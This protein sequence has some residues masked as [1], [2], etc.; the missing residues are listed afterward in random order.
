MSG[1]TRTYHV[2]NGSTD[3]RA[4]I[5]VALHGGGGNGPRLAEQARLIQKASAEGS[6]L[7]LP[8]GAG[9]LSNRDTWF[10]EGCCAY[11]SRQSLDD[12][13]IVTATLSEVIDIYEAAPFRTLLF[14]I[15]N[16]GMLAHRIGTERPESFAAI[17]IVVGSMFGG[18]IIPE[19]AVP[20]MMIT[21]AADEVVP[22]QG[23]MSSNKMAR[24]AQTKPFKPASYA[25]NFWVSA[26]S[27]VGA[28]EIT[29]VTDAKT[30]RYATC[31]GTSEVIHTCIAGA[32]HGWPGGLPSGRENAVKS[33]AI[34]AT[35]VLWSF[36]KT[37][38]RDQ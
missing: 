8:N 9:R 29:Q 23:G 28:P 1:M 33:R 36:V 3:K 14:G 32:G 19:T 24:S 31:H 17:G 27:C 38:Y 2:F 10:A 7:V 25:L 4:P 26:N 16:G 21:G 18:E 5:L 11:A 30:T 20:I 13:A 6:I 35:D 22:A 34:I 12:V 37:K 15:S